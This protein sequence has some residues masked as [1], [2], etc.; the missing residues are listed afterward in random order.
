MSN[1]TATANVAGSP[2]AAPAQGSNSGSRKKRREAMS[3]ARVYAD[4]N[5]ERP[6]SY[7]DYEKLEIEWSKNQDDYEVIRKIGRGKYS[8]VFEGINV[9]T[10]QMCVIKVRFSF[11]KTP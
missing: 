2:N 6:A 3:V 1:P 7:W 11:F 10:N 5:S 8:E 9:K 4:V